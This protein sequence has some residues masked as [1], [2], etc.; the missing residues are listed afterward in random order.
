MDVACDSDS[1]D[2]VGEE[3]E[4]ERKRTRC[5]K[6]RMRKGRVND[7]Q[8]EHCSG[9]VRWNSRRDPFSSRLVPTAI[10]EDRSHDSIRTGTSEFGDA[11]AAPWDGFERRSE[12]RAVVL[13]WRM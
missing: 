13:Q 8:E 9:V 4:Y 2:G 3:D 11:G 7:E 6:I 1:Q 12:F 5:E 10:A